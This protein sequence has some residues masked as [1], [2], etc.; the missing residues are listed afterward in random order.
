MKT[1]VVL[2][3][4]R[5]ACEMLK[6]LLPHILPDNVG[7]KCIP[8]EGKQDLEAQM[9]RKLRGWHTPKTAFMVL[10][11]QDSGDCRQTKSRLA[12]K[13][14]AAGRHETVVRI[15]CCELESWYFGDL[16]AT[17]KGLGIN[18]LVRFRN[19]RKYRVPD[20][21]VSPSRELKKITQN[22]YE[23]IAGSRAIGPELGVNPEQNT[24]VSFRHFLSGIKKAL[25]TIDNLPQCQQPRQPTSPPT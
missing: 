17:E 24:S 20:S 21:I 14:R 11:D 7:W 16:E 4:E 12:Q 2:L 8:F 1:L 9:E 13:C 18:G 15:A 23:K 22:R 6:G 10:R 3:E 25:Q 5:S 19:S